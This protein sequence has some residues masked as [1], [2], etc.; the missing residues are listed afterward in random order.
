MESVL[1]MSWD[2][3]LQIKAKSDLS[4]GRSVSVAAWETQ[5]KQFK[6]GQKH[7]LLAK[8]WQ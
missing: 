6:L 1:L 7:W 5:K 3:I 4:I 2:F 8:L